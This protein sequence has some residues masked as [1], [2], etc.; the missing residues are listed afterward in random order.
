[1]ATTEQKM[2]TG[3]QR[4]RASEN[5]AYQQR[6]KIRRWICKVC[7]AKTNVSHY[8]ARKNEPKVAA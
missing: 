2:C 5:G 4:L 6:G 1:M 8:A 7:D 3:C